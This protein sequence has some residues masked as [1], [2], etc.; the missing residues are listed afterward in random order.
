[1]AQDFSNIDPLEWLRVMQDHT[2]ASQPQQAPP[3]VQQQQP[4]Q[5][6]AAMQRMGTPG[7]NYFGPAHQAFMQAL[8]AP[9]NQQANIAAMT[10]NPTLATAI[11]GTSTPYTPQ[12]IPQSK[13][14]S[15]G[16]G[17]VPVMVDPSSNP[18]GVPTAPPPAPPAPPVPT[19]QPAPGMI[20]NGN[21]WS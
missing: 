20:F 17:N 12:G 3:P 10:T 6:P 5:S 15:W 8:S 18:G 11:N 9:T 1:M 16:P 7:A 2:P 21:G 14:L 19:P 4:M 13:R